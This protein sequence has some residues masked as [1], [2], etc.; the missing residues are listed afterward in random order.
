MTSLS[1]ERAKGHSTSYDVIELGYNYRLDDIRS[2]IGLVQLSK[3][4]DD[5]QKRTEVRKWYIE[6]L[7]NVEEIT[8]PFKDY[9][10]FSSNYI[11]PIVLRN[12]S[13]EKREYIRNK[14]AVAGIQT[15][16]HYPAVHKFSIY[17]QFSTNLP[18][19]E[20]VSENLIT[21]PMYSKLSNENV[22]FISKSLIKS[23]SRG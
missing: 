18:I 22:K 13:A 1:Y 6:E 14:L 2:A 8:I 10:Y 16:V 19:T 5:L 4:K 17:R 20:Y 7:S 23:L 11:F 3:L 9:P 15:S 21:L 12:S